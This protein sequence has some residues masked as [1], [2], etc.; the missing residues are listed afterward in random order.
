MDLSLLQELQDLEEK[1]LE[2]K[3]LAEKKI[4]AGM[5]NK[6][7]GKDLINRA[8]AVGNSERK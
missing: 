7:S 8:S 4:E 2:T 3:I 1:E 6:T 5:S